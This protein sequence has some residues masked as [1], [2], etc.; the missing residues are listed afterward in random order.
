ML[1]FVG[2]IIYNTNMLTISH[3][4]HHYFGHLD[5]LH[6]V[7][8]TF[9][10]GVTLLLGA[11]GD[12]KTSICKLIAGL[13]TPEQG[14]ITLDGR[15]LVYGKE[16]DVGMIF[17]DLALLEN[18]SL[19]YNITYPLRIRRIPKEQWQ[20]RIDPLL[21]RWQIE[22]YALQTTAKRAPAV[23]RVKVAL[24][25]AQ[26]YRH[27][28]LLV[29]NP[30]SCLAPDER[31]EVF[32]L[33]CR[34]LPSMGDV[35]LYV[36]DRVAEARSLE[37]DA[38]LLSQGYLVAKGSVP[39]LAADPPCLYAATLLVPLYQVRDGVA[40]EGKVYFDGRFVE[41][42]YPKAYQ[43]Q[44]VTV[45]IAPDAVA[46]VEQA[47]G[48]PIDARLYVEGSYYASCQGYWSRCDLPIGTLVAIRFA[49]VDLFDPSQQL[50]IA[51]QKD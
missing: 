32:A 34:F 15:P 50:R 13:Y 6:D 47:D 16:G 39:A 1:D 37:A 49:K 48:A 14:D 40:Q 23:L 17:D 21:A 7:D 4:H 28:V 27:P 5:T 31:D 2:A 29:D 10:K 8:V 20:E 38:V 24:A 22:P 12:G 35:V 45:G 18:R 41:I 19:F 42:G 3:L 11:K 51:T 33:L 30:L 46:F 26:L 36:T 25:R 43:D 9:P 44:P